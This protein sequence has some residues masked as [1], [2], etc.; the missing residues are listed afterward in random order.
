[1]ILIFGDNIVVDELPFSDIFDYE[2][3]TD[4][5]IMDIKLKTVAKSSSCEGV[6]I[7]DDYN[8]LFSIKGLEEKVYYFSDIE[9]LKNV[10]NKGFVSNNESTDEED[11]SKGNDEISVEFLSDTSENVNEASH[12]TSDQDHDY[13]IS[14]KDNILDN[15]LKLPTL[16]VDLDSLKIQLENK[17]R[18]IDQK[19]AIIMELQ[20]Q[21][22]SLYKLQENHML[23]LKN[24]Y[25]LKIENAQ[26]IIDKL[27]KDLDNF[28]LDEVSSRFLKYK[29]Y[30]DNY[31]G[32]LKE[33]LTEEERS[34]LNILR[35]KYHILVSGGMSSFYDMMSAIK[36]KIEKG[37]K[38][39]IVDMTNDYYLMTVFKVNTKQGVMDIFENDIQSVSRKIGNNVEY[40]PSY[41]FN[42]IIFLS[43]D[44]AKFINKI[45]SYAGGR[46]VIIIVNG[47]HAFTS[48][49]CVSK[50]ADIGDVYVFTSANPANIISLL[51]DVMFFESRIKKIVILKYIDTLNDII[52]KLLAS[53]YSVLAIKGDKLDWDKIGLKI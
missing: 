29:M 18:I 47:L 42:D 13:D 17:Q 1:M 31:K 28:A 6:F 11:V 25:E 39:L 19:D 24:E 15:V 27:K 7:Q 43:L 38:A 44:W 36:D 2:I 48:R 30:A 4:Q 37:T 26:R 40:I 53:K 12:V 32:V 20:N 46:D 14:V 23:E 21:I 34:Q 45:D 49:V 10:L 22:D 50:L 16:E 33:G 5:K 9:S 35:S 3:V 52:N 8:S 41:I 51:K